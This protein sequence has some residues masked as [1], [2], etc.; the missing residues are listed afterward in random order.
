[1]RIQHTLIAALLA[2]LVVLPASAGGKS[3]PKPVA[4]AEAGVDYSSVCHPG[5]VKGEVLCETSESYQYCKT[6]EGKGK[7]RVEGDDP[8]KP[9]KVIS[10]QQ[11]G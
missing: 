5:A 7:M 11:A 1:M 3:K 6:L 4:E 2:S 9:T 8:D 10:C